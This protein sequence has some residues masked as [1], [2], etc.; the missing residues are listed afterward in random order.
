VPT[1]IEIARRLVRF[2]KVL[3][4]AAGSFAALG[5]GVVVCLQFGFWLVT[6]AWTP[7]PVSRI[8]EFSD[9][10]VPR[11]Y[12]PASVSASGTARVDGPGIVEWVLD[13]PAVVV[14]FVALAVLALIYASLTSVEN[15]LPRGQAGTS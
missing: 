5:M 9:I 13:L 6:K 4:V 1:V 8:L 11:R 7:F 10:N 12:F 3:V 15:T 14:L 2:T